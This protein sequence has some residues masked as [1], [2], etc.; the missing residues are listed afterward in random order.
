MAP[1]QAHVNGSSPGMTLFWGDRVLPPSPRT[2]FRWFVCAW[3]QYLPQ[4][5]TTW[6]LKGLGNFS[7][8]TLAIQSTGGIGFGMYLLV[9]GRQNLVTWTPPLV[10][11]SFQACLRATPPS[12]PGH[13]HIHFAYNALN[14]TELHITHY[15]IRNLCRVSVFCSALYATCPY[16]VL[17]YIY[18]CNRGR[19]NRVSSWRYLMSATELL[20]RLGF[21]S[22]R[23]YLSAKIKDSS[24]GLLTV[25]RGPRAVVMN[26]CFLHRQHA[27]AQGG[28]G[29]A[30]E[31][32]VAPLLQQTVIA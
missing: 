5:A 24:K 11:G 30:S 31:G 4:I 19:R 32:E 21:L 29:H 10:T 14:I 18:I 12:P 3:L 13:I 6:R 27:G 8:L 7:R 28:D 15:T 1:F 22:F 25:M 23:V 26:A 2:R 20:F 9:G 17:L 16:Y